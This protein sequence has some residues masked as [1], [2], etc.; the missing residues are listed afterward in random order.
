MA[1]SAEAPSPAVGDGEGLDDGIPRQIV[2]E[3]DTL[4]R[5]G[6]CEL[7]PDRRGCGGPGIVPACAA[8]DQEVDVEHPT[9]QGGET[10]QNR[11]RSRARAHADDARPRRCMTTVWGVVRDGAQDPDRVHRWR[12]PRE[13]WAPFTRLDDDSLTFGA[14]RPRVI[15]DTNSA[16]SAS[17]SGESEDGPDVMTTLPVVQHLVECRRC[18]G[19]GR[20]QQEER[21]SSR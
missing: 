21:A 10:R 4:A 2:E 3:P 12:T 6:H 8:P 13:K 16:T 18:M 7:R 19:T 11:V 14:D 9:A 17:S 1:S 20:R 5:I 15:L